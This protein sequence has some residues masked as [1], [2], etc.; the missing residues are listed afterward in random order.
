MHEEEGGLHSIQVEQWR[1]L[2]VP[3]W[4]LPRWPSHPGGLL[5]M[6]NSPRRA[7]CAHLTIE[8][9]SVPP[10]SFTHRGF[11]SRGLHDQG[12]SAVPAITVSDHPKSLWVSDPKFNE[13]RNTRQDSFCDALHRRH[14]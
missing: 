5:L 14:L 2:N 9:N 4:K 6:C 12:K 1:V 11:E 3:V 10:A 7:V 8:S 13:L